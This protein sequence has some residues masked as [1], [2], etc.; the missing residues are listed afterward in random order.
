MNFFKLGQL[1]MDMCQLA[2]EPFKKE[3]KV[4]SV[5]SQSS[6]SKSLCNSTL[7]LEKFRKFITLVVKLRLMNRF[8]L[9]AREIETNN[10]R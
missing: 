4:R 6:S 2:I 8:L 9:H 5:Q 3:S 1:E 10:L 7:V